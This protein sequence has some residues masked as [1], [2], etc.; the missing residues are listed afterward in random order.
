MRKRQASDSIVAVY[1]FQSIG[2]E[3]IPLHIGSTPSVKYKFLGLV[4]A[5]AFNVSA[6]TDL[7]T[8]QG[9]GVSSPGVGGI[10]MRS[11]EQVNL[12]VWGG[13]SGVYDTFTQPI[14]TDSKGQ[15]VTIRD[16]W[17]VQANLGAYGVHSWRRAQLGLDYVGAYRHYPENSFY[18]GSDHALS[19]GYTF[20]KSREWVF[21]LRQSA[22]TYSYNTGGV[23]ASISSDPNTIVKPAVALFDTRTYYLD[24]S[25][26]VTWMPS[27][28]TSYTFGGNGNK[29]IYRSNAL[30]QMN[31]YSLSGSVNHIVTRNNSIGASYSHTH[32]GYPNYFGASD[33]NTFEG[34]YGTT[35]GRAWTFNLRGGVFIAESLSLRAVNLDPVL[36]ALLGTKL[37]LLPLYTKSTNASGLAGLTRQF[38]RANLTLQ[39][40]RAVSPGNGVFLASRIDSAIARVSYTAVRKLNFGVDGGYYS[41][42]SLGADLQKDN[43]FSAGSGLTYEVMRW[44]HLTARYDARHQE[45]DLGHHKQSGYWVSFGV[46]FSPGNVPLSLW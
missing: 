45:L 35:F 32:Y 29:I 40:A 3:N 15:L 20:Q 41:L 12:R 4:L 6:Q 7:S 10:G 24:S 36:A 30:A 43:E 26:F 16:L 46:A 37:I 39:Y 27:P 14:T 34:I 13:V 42:T 9:P 21:N 8:Y 11:G 25:M 33:I 31:G 1:L 19:L 17:G 23:A 44:V 28:R 38:K 2:S 22:G 5:T 18:D